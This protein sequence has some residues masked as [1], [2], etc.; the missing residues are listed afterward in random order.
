[1]PGSGAAPSSDDRLILASSSPRRRSIHD[2]LGLPF[3]VAPADV[4]ESQRAGEEP[5]DLAARLAVAKASAV[6]ERFPGRLAIGSDT[7]VALN[8]E[9][10]GKPVSAEDAARMLRALRGRVHIVITAVAVARAGDNGIETWHATDATRVWMRDYGE[11][12]I[13]AYVASGD[14]MDKAGAYAVQHPVFRPVARLEG[15][16]LTV[17]GLSLPALSSVLVRAGRP[18]PRIHSTTLDAICRSCTDRSLLLSD[19]P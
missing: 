18:L 17:V 8:N 6:A 19:G 3:D 4:D 13:S 12:E 15:C 2:A 7:V 11:D 14:P 1:L 10:L 9:S 16:Y 5:G